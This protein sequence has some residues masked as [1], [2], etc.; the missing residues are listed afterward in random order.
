MTLNSQDQAD[1]INWSVKNWNRLNF[2][3]ATLP[4]AESNPHVIASRWSYFVRL[5]R[6]GYGRKVRFIRVLQ[7]HPGGHGWHVHALADQYIPAAVILHYAS[8]AGLGRMDFQMVSGSD[9]QKVCGYLARYISRDL[10]K[11]DKSAK[12]VRMV[13]ASGSLGSVPR[14]WVRVK[15]MII[16][17]DFSRLSKSLR[18]CCELC[19]CVLATFVN[20]LELFTLA[21]PAALEQWRNLN[22]GFAF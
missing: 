6:V 14:W 3:T 17:Q 20:P 12:G 22:T 2:I 15:D 18:A 11:R 4:F 21:P 13:T 16:E 1:R 19:G 8:L 7:K 10:R 5:F 9:R